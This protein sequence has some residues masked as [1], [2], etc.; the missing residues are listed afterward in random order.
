M[1]RAVLTLWLYLAFCVFARAAMADTTAVQVVG[2]GNR[3]CVN[4]KCYE[5]PPSEQY[6]VNGQMGHEANGHPLICVDMEWRR[7]ALEPK[8]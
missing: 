2:K 6:C 1:N 8:P 3:I 5:T 7:I 4:G